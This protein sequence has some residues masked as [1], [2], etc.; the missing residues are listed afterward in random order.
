VE[1]DLEAAAEAEA[2]LGELIERCE[3]AARVDGHRRPVVEPGFGAHPAGARR[4]RQ[5]AK[6][7]WVGQEHQAVGKPSLA[8]HR[9]RRAEHA[10]RGAVGRV[11]EQD[12][13]DQTDAARERAARPLR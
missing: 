13:A 10:V 6:A 3:D 4:P 7:G 11:L 12:R 1:L 2:S 9:W 5:D 8:R